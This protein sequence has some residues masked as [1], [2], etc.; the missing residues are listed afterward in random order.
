M[1]NGELLVGQQEIH[2]ADSNSLLRMYDLANQVLNTS[3]LQLERARADK[4]IQRIARELQ[5]RKII[6]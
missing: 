3:K 1:T 4:S 5:K 2:G 6:F